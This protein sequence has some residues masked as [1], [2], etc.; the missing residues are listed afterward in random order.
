MIR[1]LLIMIGLAALMVG[2]GALVLNIATYHRPD[3]LTASL[4]G[5]YRC[6]GTVAWF[7]G[8]AAIAIGAVLL[9]LVGP[10]RPDGGGRPGRWMHALWGALLLYVG[11]NCVFLSSTNSVRYVDGHWEVGG[12]FES[13]HSVPDP[14]AAEALWGGLR[15][16]SGVI[17]LEAFVCGMISFRLATPPPK[18]EA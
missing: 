14:E 1:L 4:P 16:G 2:V 15:F 7:G 9:L 5:W 6:T 13:W 3:W 18:S 12:R 17:L 10:R 11:A 8:P